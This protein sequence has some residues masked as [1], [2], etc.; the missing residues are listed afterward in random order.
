MLFSCCSSLLHS[1]IMRLSVPSLSPY[2]LQL[3]NY[4]LLSI[5]AFIYLVLMAL[6]LLIL[7][8]S[9][10]LLRFCFL[11][12]VLVFSCKISH[13]GHINYPYNCFSSYF[14]FCFSFYCF[15]A[16]FFVS[17]AVTCWRCL[18]DKNNIPKCIK[19]S[20]TSWSVLLAFTPNRLANKIATKFVFVRT[21]LITWRMWQK[22]SF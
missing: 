15:F 20:W 4:W 19:I 16:G 6:F 21:Q 10:H 11:C 1:F 18:I 14:Y 2:N 17:I 9:F 7:T 13:V 12:D 3:L 8:D 22:V 5:F